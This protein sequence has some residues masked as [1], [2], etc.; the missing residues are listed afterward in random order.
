MNVTQE[1]SALASLLHQWASMNPDD[2]KND[3][4]SYAGLFRLLAKQCNHITEFG[5]RNGISTAAF[6]SGCPAAFRAYDLVKQPNILMLEGI[7]RMIG[8]DFEFIEADTTEISIAPTDM[9]FVDACH[10]YSAV[11][12]ELRNSTMVKK[13]IVFHDTTECW[14]RENGNPVYVEGI[15]R[16]IQELIAKGE[17]VITSHYTKGSGLMILSRRN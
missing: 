5:T 2:G 10:R 16:A 8:I 9:L 14:E 13:Y 6:L 1:K 7:T 15:G 12:K 17:W 11:A 4:N 3:I